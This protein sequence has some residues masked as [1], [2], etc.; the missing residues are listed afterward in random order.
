MYVIEKVGE[1][2]YEVRLQT[3]RARLL[4]HI[5]TTKRKAEEA[6][7]RFEINGTHKHLIR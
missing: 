7:E 6:I 3:S 5:A 4:V 2:K 1:H